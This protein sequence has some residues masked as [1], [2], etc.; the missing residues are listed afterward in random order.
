MISEGERDGEV[1]SRGRGDSDGRAGGSKTGVVR[2]M[3]VEIEQ[4]RWG[5][6]TV[7]KEVTRVVRGGGGR[8]VNAGFPKRLIEYYLCLLD[9]G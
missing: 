7:S 1:A 4:Q 5:S 9:G 6:V 3:F 8:W 2:W